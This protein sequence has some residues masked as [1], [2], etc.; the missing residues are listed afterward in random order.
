MNK[1]Q[2]EKIATASGFIAALD[3]SGGSTPRALK[4]YGVEES[5]W[6]N[7]TEM[8]DLVHDMRARI[9]TSQVFEG[10]RI[11]GAILFADT[12][13]RDV[14]GRYTAD[15]LWE[16][17]RVVPFLKVDSGLAER[18]HEA[19]GKAARRQPGMGQRRTR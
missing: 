9:V 3:Q 12:M 5:E 2:R 13:D 15:Y 11:L 18:V 1:E 17:K 4:L 14:E 8:F 16:V 7:D 19:A 10:S 6:S